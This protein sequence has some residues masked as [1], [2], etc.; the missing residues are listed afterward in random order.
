MSYY[1]GFVALLL[2]VFY[3]WR[4]AQH[5][6]QVISARERASA[7]G[8]QVEIDPVWSAMGVSFMPFILFYGAFASLLLIGG[9]FLSDLK[10]Y[11][12]LFDL[13]GLLTLIVAY[14]GWILIRTHYNKLGLD[15]ASG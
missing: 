6:K 2:G 4:S 3:F 5:R 15:F 7:N 9:F 11:L 1:I 10:M 12:S 13:F 14:T 8:G